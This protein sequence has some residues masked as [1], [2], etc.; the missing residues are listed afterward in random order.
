MLP[1]R[2]SPTDVAGV[3]ETDPAVVG[4]SL[5]GLNPFINIANEM[6]T[7]C[8]TFQGQGYSASRLAVIETWVAAHFYAVRDPRPVTEQ[9]GA[10]RQTLQKVVDIGL[11]ATQWGQTAMRIDTYG[12]LAAKNN[13]AGR[14]RDFHLGIFHLGTPRRA[15]YN[16]TDVGQPGGG[17]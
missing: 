17:V 11:D 16:P 10:A 2:C 15:T 12:G 4:S 3:I 1:G 7:E 5:N 6:V 8:C 9:L 13:K 14:M